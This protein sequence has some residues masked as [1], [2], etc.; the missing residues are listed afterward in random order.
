MSADFTAR[1]IF[2]GLSIAPC[3]FPIRKLPVTGHASLSCDLTGSREW[4]LL[5]VWEETVELRE[6]HTKVA[7]FATSLDILCSGLLNNFSLKHLN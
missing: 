1:D 2:R 5:R 6:P 3:E 7:I 4:R